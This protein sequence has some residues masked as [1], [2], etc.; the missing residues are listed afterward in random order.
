MLSIT[1][2]LFSF[3]EYFLKKTVD[4]FLSN[5]T[6]KKSYVGN[7][8][9][10]FKKSKIEITDIHV[11]NNKDYSY[12]ELLN[13]EKIIIL[14]DLE[15]IFSNEVIIKDLSIHNAN[16]YIEIIDDK[17]ENDSENKNKKKDN[18]S[19]IEKIQDNYKPKTY[20]KKKR[21]KNFLINNL[22]IIKPRA[23]L[24][25]LDEYKYEN[26]KLSDMYYSNVGNFSSDVQHFKDVFKLFLL[27]FFLRIPDFEIRKRIKKIYSL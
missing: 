20:K 9:L 24:K 6:N 18:I 10:D 2:I 12:P 13:C 5:I 15:S 21:D 25:F 14:I 16:F 11:L 4:I 22:K 19:I 3:H 17:L 7:V 27:D 1:I 26:F 23:N 8:D